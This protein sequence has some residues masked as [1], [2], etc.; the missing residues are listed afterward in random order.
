MDKNGTKIQP[1]AQPGDFKFAKLGESGELN[2]DDDRTFIGD[3]NPDLIYGFNL[4]FSYKNFDV[5]M[6]F[7]ELLEM[8]SGTLLKE[9]LLQQDARMRWRMLTQKHGQKTGIWML[10][11]HA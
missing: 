4:G 9:A 7:Q 2:D 11:I 10:Y 3:P 8:T 6:A 1:N 5:S